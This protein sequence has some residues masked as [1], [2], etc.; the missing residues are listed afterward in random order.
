MSEA[1]SLLVSLSKSSNAQLPHRPYSGDGIAS[2][3]SPNNEMLNRLG[4]NVNQGKENISSNTL[5]AQNSHHSAGSSPLSITPV[6]QLLPFFQP[7][8]SSHH[9][10]PIYN[11][12]SSHRSFSSSTSSSISSNDPS[13]TPVSSAYHL[14]AASSSLASR[15]NII[16]SSHS[17][18]ASP[19]FV[20]G[21]LPDG[22]GQH[23]SYPKTENVPYFPWYSVVPYF[24]SVN[25]SPTNTATNIHSS[26]ISLTDSECKNG[27]VLY[28]S[29]SQSVSPPHSAPPHIPS[30]FNPFVDESED[31]DV[32]IKY[33]FDGGNETQDS[34]DS[35]PTTNHDS[36][37][38]I[39]TNSANAS[40]EKKKS[41]R[42]S[43]SLSSINLKGLQIYY[44]FY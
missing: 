14:T 2:S 41:K 13:P 26:L 11:D 44:A 9:S 33:K 8:S 27:G 15:S 22:D 19:F 39:A 29:A 30:Q 3:I 36:S 1:A 37:V 5:Y 42:R 38:H 35:Q 40:K 16:I 6:T 18:L 43:H 17:P 23:D 31:D 28:L 24:S 7:I 4:R 21:K 34:L 20:D 10:L 12:T 32:F 25:S